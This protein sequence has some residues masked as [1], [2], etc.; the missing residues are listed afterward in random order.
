MAELLKIMWTI[1]V[2]VCG[3]ERSFS[4]LRR[5][6]TY[7]RNTTGQERLTC[8]ALINIEQDYEIDIDA[9]LGFDDTKLFNSTSSNKIKC[10]EQ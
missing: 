9:I 1:P 3:C 10:N 8:L 2:N 5:I 4:A 6:K 7:I